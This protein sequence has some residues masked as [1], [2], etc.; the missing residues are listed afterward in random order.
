[1]TDIQLLERE[2]E[3]M[4]EEIRMLEDSNIDL[5]RKVQDVK[6]VLKASRAE[7]LLHMGEMTAQELR[8]L[9]A[10]FNW[11]LSKLEK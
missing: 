5:E 9:K 6:S 3:L 7:I 8:T 1:M 2:L 11:A 10:G 4:E